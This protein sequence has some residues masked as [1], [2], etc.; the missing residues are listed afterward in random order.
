MAMPAHFAPRLGVTSKSS[1]AGITGK[2]GILQV[3]AIDNGGTGAIVEYFGPG[4][5][6]ISATGKGTICNMGAE[7]G[8]TTSL[9]AY[10]D[11]VAR[12][13]K[14]TGREAVA[15]AADAVAHHLRRPAVFDEQDALSVDAATKHERHAEAQEKEQEKEKAAEA[16][17][18]AA[19]G[20]GAQGKVLLAT[21]K[22]DV[23]DIGK[24]IVGVVL[25]CN[26]YEVIDLGVMVPCEKILDTALA[27]GCDLVGL[28]GLITPSLDEMVH[29]AREMQRQGLGLPG[30]ARHYA[31]RRDA[32]VKRLGVAAVGE[33]GD[34]GRLA[35]L[36]DDGNVISRHDGSDDAE[37]ES[38]NQGLEHATNP[39]R[40]RAKTRV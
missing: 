2:L 15:D 22:G 23:H 13:L 21:V 26:N 32:D 20:T 35:M 29:V 8:A 40:A 6:A 24:N 33:H 12:Y 30:R 7:I 17:K 27:E 10:D 16:E 37:Q 38:E 31:I 5:N 14:S 9:F 4:A 39:W 28:S 1:G 18:E 25:G 36:I 34:F 3:E 11:A 19:G